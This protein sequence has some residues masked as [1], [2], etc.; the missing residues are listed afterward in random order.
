MKPFL[1]HL[2]TS[3]LP[4]VS[5]TRS[6]PILGGGYTFPLGTLGGDDRDTFFFFPFYKARV[7]SG[8]CV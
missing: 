1:L 7:G 2:H 4:R 5:V 6:V 8:S 3:T